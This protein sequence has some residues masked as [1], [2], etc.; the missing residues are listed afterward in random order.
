MDLT[1]TKENFQKWSQQTEEEKENN[2]TIIEIMT[3]LPNKNEKNNQELLNE[4]NKLQKNNEGTKDEEDN[5]VKDE[6][7]NEVKDEEDNKVKNNEEQ[8]Y[9]IPYNNMILYLQNKNKHIQDKQ[10][11]YEYYYENLN[12]VYAKLSILLIIISSIITFLGSAQLGD[13]YMNDQVKLA[14]KILVILF[15]FIITVLSSVLKFKLYKEKIE[16]IGKYMEQLELLIDDIDIFIKKIETGTISDQDF[17]TKLNEISTIVTRTNT[18][19]FNIRSDKY[20]HFYQKL[21]LISSKKWNIQ[22]EIKTLNEK[23]YNDFLK[24]R[25]TTMKERL[26]LKKEFKTIEQN[27]IDQDINSFYNNDLFSYS[28]SSENKEE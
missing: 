7:D 10:T 6:E 1:I 13:I 26:E 18:K 9:L 3:H 19:L 5:E 20:Y 23:K 16:S 22:H 2:D 24:Q 11:I 27:V 4:I 12:D 8:T 15:S 17:F 21:K 28:K 25:L 14:F